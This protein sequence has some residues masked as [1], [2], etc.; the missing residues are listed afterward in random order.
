MSTFLGGFV[1]RGMW[2]LSSLARD[3]TGA[4]ALGAWS[5]NHWAPRKLVFYFNVCGDY[6]GGP[7]AHWS[8][9][10]FDP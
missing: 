1:S 5:P 10:R 3:R 4:P 6:P 8:R 7:V 9:H 2:D